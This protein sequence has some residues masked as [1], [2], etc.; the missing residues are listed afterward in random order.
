MYVAGNPGR[1]RI[2]YGHFYR[3]FPKEWVT[4]LLVGSVG[5]TLL[6]VDVRLGAIV[7][8]IAAAVFVF[9]SKQWKE[10]FAD[11]DVCPAVVVDVE[12][13]LV[14][15]YTDLSKGGEPYPVV[16]IVKQP[17]NQAA[18]GPFKRGTR[19]ATV[20]SYNGYAYEPNW[21]N[22]SPFLVNCGTRSKKAGV[23]HGFG[24]SNPKRERGC[25]RKFFG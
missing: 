16:K 19:L 17:L 1:V 24:H 18:G 9:G 21:R 3:C 15:V 2:N 25:R 22:F 14:A 8:G 23:D 4:W 10:L 6:A 5:L 7:S 13:N 11:C 20:A 12:R